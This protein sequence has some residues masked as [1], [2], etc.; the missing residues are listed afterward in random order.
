M[1]VRAGG[2]GSAVV[3]LVPNLMSA[4]VVCEDERKNGH[5]HGTGEGICKKE[6]DRKSSRGMKSK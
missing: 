5:K 4:T 3:P 1:R 2:D 6:E